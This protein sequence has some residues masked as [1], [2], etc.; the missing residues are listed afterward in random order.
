MITKGE[1]L[2]CL[3]IFNL[4]MVVCVGPIQAQAISNTIENLS[5]EAETVVNLKDDGSAHIFE[6]MVFEQQN[7]VNTNTESIKSQ[8]L[9]K[10]KREGYNVSNFDCD[11]ENTDRGMTIK[12][13][14][15]IQ[16][17]ATAINGIWSVKPSTID[18]CNVI[19]S[20]GHYLDIPLN[21]DI[22]SK[23]K[24]VLP[25]R[26]N[27]IDAG[28]STINKKF[29]R[30]SVSLNRKVTTEGDRKIV[31]TEGDSKFVKGEVIDLNKFVELAKLL[32]FRYE[33][34][35]IVSN[36][37]YINI[38]NYKKSLLS[39]EF[40]SQSNNTVQSNLTTY[41][42][43]TLTQASETAT[44]SNDKITFI[45]YDDGNFRMERADGTYLLYPSGTS[46]ITIRIDGTDYAHNGGQY[47]GNYISTPLTVIDHS[48]A[49][50]E[51]SFLG[52]DL[53]L[54][55]D[56]F[57]EEGTVKFKADVTNN[58][59]QNHDV[60]V[61]FLFDTQLGPNDGA[62]FDRLVFAWWPSAIGST[63]DYTSNPNQRFYTPGYTTSPESDS[64]VLLYWNMGLI[65]PSSSVSAMTYYGTEDASLSNDID[66]LISKTE[67][68][69]DA[70]K[71]EINNDGARYD[72]VSCLADLTWESLD[73]TDVSTWDW[74]KLGGDVLMGVRGA[75]HMLR[76]LGA[77]GYG[78]YV[79]LLAEEGAFIAGI[80]STMIA[81]GDLVITQQIHDSI[82]ATFNVH[83]NNKEEF[84]DNAVGVLKGEF[85]QNDQTVNQVFSTMDSR[86]SEFEN[87][88][89][90]NAPPADQFDYPTAIYLIDTQIKKIQD[91]RE[92]DGVDFL[93]V[94]GSSRSY[95]LGAMRVNE[96]RV[97]EFAD[98]IRNHNN[99]DWILFTTAAC[100]FVIGSVVTGGAL[101]A[102][103]IVAA[104]VSAARIVNSLEGLNGK[105]KLVA[106]WH[107]SFGELVSMKRSYPY[108]L[109]NNLD[110]LTGQ[111]I[112]WKLDLI[113]GEVTYFSMPS[114]IVLDENEDYGTVTTNIAV[115][116]TGSLS[117]EVTALTHIFRNR[118]SYSDLIPSILSFYGAIPYPLEPYEPYSLDPGQEQ[119]ISFEYTL[120]RNSM[121]GNP[122][123]VYTLIGLDE[124]ALALKETVIY[125]G[126]Q[127]EIDQL[128]SNSYTTIDT[129]ISTGQSVS[130]DVAIS[131]STE[132]AQFIAT[133][134]GSDMDLHVYD[135]TGNHVGINY[136]TGHVELEIS[137]AQYSGT[138]DI[139][140]WIVIPDAGGNSYTVE[141]VGVDVTIPEQVVVRTTEIPQRPAIM[142]VNPKNVEMTLD[143]DLTNRL[144]IM[145][146]ES[147]GQNDLNDVSVS[148]DGEV[149]PWIELS[150]T[151][152]GDI[153]A[154]DS[155]LVGATVNIPTNAVGG[156]HAGIIHVTGID[157]STG[158]ELSDDVN[159]ILTIPNTTS[160]PSAASSSITG[161]PIDR[162]RVDADVYATGS[163]FTTG[164]N[165]DIYVVP[166]Q[167]WNDGN[168]I[169]SDVT[170]AVE[171]V[172]VVNGAIATVLVWHAP[173]VIGEY[174]IV[175]DANQ[176]GVYDASTDGLDSGS[177]GFVVI[178]MPS[179][180]VPALAP[181]G[182]IALIGLLC[183][184]GMIMIR[185]RF[186]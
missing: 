82:E 157:S 39:N 93:E 124:K 123:Y 181:I 182:I 47:L 40:N 130:E 160:P 7:I 114:E 62:P 6:I 20:Y 94:A 85:T 9:Y 13:S 106:I 77:G 60:K 83:E 166:D 87:Y 80:G 122:Y 24:F 73:A 88:A 97:S 18:I 34:D 104:G 177:P 98:S 36:E 144:A 37:S 52:D 116:N 139:P 115:E 16:N 111:I 48:H 53:D 78:S 64:C 59:D 42:L 96:Y 19:G 140:E 99:L 57:L 50:I 21:L 148:V 117:C 128:Q 155:I 101:T 138:S 152:I 14:Y 92:L 61:R 32:E 55:L 169:P 133:Y 183:V 76:T 75:H 44:L 168:Q 107:S 156:E 38:I 178:D 153:I 109:D 70:L 63:Y 142:T 121:D 164:T 28:P 74:I 143:V 95:R 136:D 134:P 146:K 119:T 58:G 184:I 105:E 159:I 90:S 22:Q 33:I 110:W 129:F 100:L 30:S 27:V 72:G 69:K 125:V 56:Y 3:V 67:I 29:G 161:V 113:D 31:L 103:C 15:D 25:E 10:L 79:S 174:D 108:A 127:E 84:H 120:P 91:T 102:V 54:R 158:E 126:T 151:D 11:V 154:G 26:S 8:A 68:L 149:A 176:N 51:Y 118:L 46:A 23:M 132:M 186:N 137:G 112:D 135:A 170:G 5:F 86:H 35:Q 66:L 172:S 89:R 12:A 2:S 43:Q 180:P 45:L 49:M 162:F 179:V 165:V 141:I 145:V 185:R 4:L 17:Y 1:I 71:N 163:G 81:G 171:T 131:D 150:I 65:S 41:S 167:D 173:L 147:G 175:I